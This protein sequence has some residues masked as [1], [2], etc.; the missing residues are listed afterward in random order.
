MRKGRLLAAAAT[1]LAAV[2][3]AGTVSAEYHLEPPADPAWSEAP[4]APWASV[5]AQRRVADGVVYFLDRVGQR[6]RRFNSATGTWLADVALGGAP[7][8]FDVDAIGIYLKYPDR[9]ERRGHDGSVF[10]YPPAGASTYPMIEVIGSAFILG[11]SDSAYLRSFDKVSGVEISA[12]YA[13]FDFTG[14]SAIESEGRVFGRT[15][16]V[17]PTDIVMVRLDASGHLLGYSDSP[18]HGGLPTASRT[19][20]REA[21]GMVADDA[22]IVYDSNDLAY[23]GSLGG[24]VDGIAW[25]SDGLVA[26]RPGS[27]SLFS[28]DLRE[29]GRI[30]APPHVL[31]V[32]A[33]GDTVYGI[34]GSI[35][36]LLMTPIDIGMAEQPVP[37]PA[38]GW[39]ESG[40]HADEILG[41]ANHLVLVNRTAHAAYGFRP[42]DWAFGT[43]VPLFVNP[44][45]AA[46][47][48]IDERLYAA[49]DGGAIHAFPMQQPGTA[50]WFAATP[51]TPFGLA[52]A[53]E[54]LFAADYSGAW[55]THYVFSPAGVMLGNPDWNYY[56]RQFEWDPAMRRMYFLRDDTSP[57]DLHFER[58]SLAGTIVEEGETPYHGDYTVD[59]PIRVSPTGSRVALGSGLVLETGGL[60]VV[61]TIDPVADIGWLFGDLYAVT[62]GG[63]PRLQRYDSGYNVVSSGRVR[64]VPRRILP[65]SN[66]FVYVADVGTTTV[67]GRLDGF[68]SKADLAIDPMS[69]GSVFAKNSV[70][71]LHVAVGNNG[72]VPSP[73]ATV[74][75]DLSALADA[76]WRCVPVAFVT[77][78]DDTLQTGELVDVIDLE[79]GGGAIYQITGRIP[80][81][82]ELDTLVPVSIQP[83]SSATDPEP[84]NNAQ[85]I[86]IPMDRL[87]TD[88][89]D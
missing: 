79:D 4:E 58:I 38:V 24:P 29:I 23:I 35:G 52:A 76:S 3:A 59:V 53:G 84:R 61:G 44:L 33:V 55:A 22:G 82:G 69:P 13:W 88:G 57:N 51:M 89:F 67:I 74:T 60:T 8:A 72:V 30:P 77:G 6:I 62:R 15:H 20:A 78:C 54:Y 31:D 27:V 65:S 49:Y 34:S 17:S 63:E 1:A 18:Y 43:P 66:G 12:M 14:T 45:H 21:G 87:F 39:A 7:D 40:A 48:S 68:L 56:S 71:T 50:E 16:D 28:S 80:A 83:V 41:D 70:V 25:L 64:G 36:S 81:G 85:V 46:Y 32:V 11:D 37:P 19:F 86:R 10:V 47:S 2:L 5:W 9:V 73:G 42:Q 26:L 75:A